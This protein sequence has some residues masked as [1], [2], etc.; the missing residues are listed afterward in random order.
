MRGRD[1]SNTHHETMPSRE[2]TPITHS[3]SLPR[4]MQ[5][6]GRAD[7][8]PR[9][10]REE[11][12]DSKHEPTIYGFTPTYRGHMRSTH[13]IHGHRWSRHSSRESIP[14]CL[15]AHFC[16]HSGVWL[17]YRAFDSIHPYMAGTRDSD[18]PKRLTC[19]CLHRSRPPRYI[20]GMTH[21]MLRAHRAQLQQA[22]TLHLR[23]HHRPLGR[24][25]RSCQCA[26]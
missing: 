16:V 11:R 9:L 12:R 13:P 24:Q 17:L 14:A 26:C 5:S 23:H 10:R 3:P 25:G 8:P 15:A 21:G 18:A 7:R 6:T 20:R 4:L 22:E 19:L 1:A 2:G